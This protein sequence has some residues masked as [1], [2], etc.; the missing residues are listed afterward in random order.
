MLPAE[1]R[2]RRSEMHRRRFFPRPA[3]RDH[4]RRVIFHR[5]LFDRQ[6]DGRQAHPEKIRLPHH[7]LL[8][9]H[10]LLSAEPF[11]RVRISVGSGWRW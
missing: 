11:S 5:D 10:R 6:R 8:H 4:P 2:K 9:R 3:D 1:T 7:R